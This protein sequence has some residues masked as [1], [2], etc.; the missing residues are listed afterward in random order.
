M[1]IN[2]QPMDLIRPEVLKMKVVPLLSDTLSEQMFS[3]LQ[4]LCGG[5]PLFR[6][7]CND[8]GATVAVLER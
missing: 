5:L 4:V 7:T 2:G 6:G 3:T 1:R 8:G